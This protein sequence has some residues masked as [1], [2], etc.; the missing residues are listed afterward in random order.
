MKGKPLFQ[1]IP[2]SALAVILAISGTS[3]S[4]SAEV[5][6]PA[7]VD[8]TPLFQNNLEY[9]VPFDGDS[10]DMCESATTP[11]NVT[12]EEGIYG[13]AARFNN[14]QGRVQLSR[15]A[16]PADYSFSI[17]MWIK[18]RNQ[19]S[20]PVLFSNKS[21][22]SGA[23][24]GFVFSTRSNNIRFNCNASGATRVDYDTNIPI[25]DD[26]WHM[27]TA[28]I[29]R[30]GGMMRMY[31]DGQLAGSGD[32]SRFAG[33]SLT[34][35]Q[36]YR[37][38]IGND[39]TGAY[40][41]ATNDCLIDE[42][43]M[44]NRVVTPD[45]VAALYETGAVYIDR[46]N[47]RVFNAN[48]GVT[49]NLEG[50][51]SLP[52]KDALIGTP[53][54]I[55]D[56]ANKDIISLNT[57]TGT[58]TG[59]KQGQT[60]VTAK[61]A[62]YPDDTIA[63]TVINPAWVRF[64][65]D[66]T[67]LQG[68]LIVGDTGR[69]T[70]LENNLT[71]NV[72]W[73]STSESILTVDQSGNFTAVAA[74]T[75]DIIVRADM[76]GGG[77]A[78]DS[79]RVTVQNKTPFNFRLIGAEWAT[80]DTPFLVNV[81]FDTANV[82]QAIE[83][84]EVTLSYDPDVLEYTTYR[85]TG[86]TYTNDPVKGE[87]KATYSFGSKINYNLSELQTASRIGTFCF[88]LKS[89]APAETT[90]TVLGIKEIL[91]QG[92]GGIDA[93]I[94]DITKRELTISINLDPE[95]DLNGDG[96]VSIGDVAISNNPAAVAK[97][98]A[99]GFYPVKRVIY[100]GSDGGG[101]FLAPEGY[102]ET[103][104][105]LGL[106]YT[107]GPKTSD[108][109]YHFEMFEGPGGLAETGS[110]TWNAQT[111]NPPI[112][113]Q[114]WTAMM[115]GYEPSDSATYTITND[116]AGSWYYP[117]EASP[118]KSIYE[119]IRNAQPNRRQATM[120]EWGSMENGIVGNNT[121][122]YQYRGGS[123]TNIDEA[124][125]MI[126][127]GE[128]LNS[129]FVWVAPDHLMD[130][131]GHATGWF[132]NTYYDQGR[133][134]ANKIEQ[135]VKT[136]D[137]N[138]GIKDD[139]VL[140]ISS[141]H[142]GYGTGHGQWRPSEYYVMIYSRGPVI[143]SG[144]KYNGDNGVQGNRG[145]EDARQ[146]DLAALYAR[147]MNIE[148]CSAWLGNTDNHPIFLTQAEVSQKGRAVENVNFVKK[149]NGYTVDLSRIQP[150]NEDAINAAHFIFSGTVETSSLS[151]RQDA[152]IIDVFEKNGQTNVVLK[153]RMDAYTEGALLYVMTTEDVTL[154]NVMLGKDSGREIYPD[155]SSE[156]AAGTLLMD[157][158]TSSGAKEKGLAYGRFEVA[159]NGETALNAMLILGVY[160]SE[161]RLLKTETFPVSVEVGGFKAVE[162]P[163]EASIG[164]TIKSFIWRES[165]YVP[166]CADSK[167]TV[168]L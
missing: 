128:M 40:A 14:R 46:Y 82:A 26:K 104:N 157:C 43:M 71:A 145:D 126:N 87:L 135:L 45:E 93:R 146:K 100:V 114:T 3:F 63:V 168:L 132:N 122:A 136:I 117:S 24:V 121:G 74:G 83:S 47:A 153:T 103:S 84:I 44:F 111:S 60:T 61:R 90:E 97:D 68:G 20:D 85:S 80:P 11:N 167:Y 72:V 10:R 41:D 150:G 31:I 38:T 151:V 67:P 152:E 116:I 109:R 32:I 19:V 123:E 17:S 23:N 78:E 101:N 88:K 29:D 137:A 154:E 57:A 115:Y 162:Y 37:A 55:Y 149:D 131:V 130:G 66:K 147:A 92:V 6:N 91:P 56:I 48:S 134:L 9:Y 30:Q 102:I 69:L 75:T 34:P 4:A 156:A 142:G 108:S 143:K 25:N 119:V 28:S 42:F 1:R 33:L 160:S 113:G 106:I 95:N 50:S 16:F 129:S 141:D 86:A 18:D 35:S 5:I 27:F 155:L 59:L 62:D 164:E 112:S 139:T 15:T 7:S 138:E 98:A 77:Y 107:Y 158:K 165:D 89:D 64:A 140:M 22:T 70:F 166:L 76:P 148:P 8:L 12:F 21:W 133:T 49:V 54:V 118:F 120:I 36:N 58:V 127:S 96:L 161:G 110:Y 81:H 52:I 94:F 125:R 163:V 105:L 99:F 13:Q 79:I 124:I 39:G 144:F 73:S 51:A 53:G 65:L 159:N 2:A